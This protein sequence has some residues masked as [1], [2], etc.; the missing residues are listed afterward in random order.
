MLSIFD[1]LSLEACSQLR[2]LDEVLGRYELVTVTEAEDEALEE[3]L[4]LRMASKA[5]AVTYGKLPRFY[6]A[7]D[8]EPVEDAE[9]GLSYLL[10][11]FRYF[12]N[13]LLGARDL[14]AANKQHLS[15]PAHGTDAVTLAELYE[16]FDRLCE[17]VKAVT[18]L[19][20][21]MQLHLQTLAVGRP[22]NWSDVQSFT[23][24][25]IAP[26]TRLRDRYFEMP[27][28]EVLSEYLAVTELT[29]RDPHYIYDFT[30]PSMLFA[31]H[32]RARIETVTLE[33]ELLSLLELTANPKE[34]SS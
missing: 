23:E 10:D 30:H 16:R 25:P 13:V 31:E 8:P 28:P 14:L 1:P 5:L 18:P 21:Q 4:E 24:S 17:A 27:T 22:A 9:Y 19:K 11:N 26:L 34:R 3:A 6:S 12:T 20:L 33:L 2:V 32:H 7:P 29:L 15:P